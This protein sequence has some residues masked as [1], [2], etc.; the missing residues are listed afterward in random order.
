MRQQNT[1]ELAER[2]FPGDP[3]VPAIA[4]TIDRDDLAL[5]RYMVMRHWYRLSRFKT[6]DRNLKKH[7]R[8]PAWLAQGLAWCSK[9][10]I[11]PP[12][13]FLEYAAR[14]SDPNYPSVKAPTP[15]KMVAAEEM[16]VAID[17]IMQLAT[18]PWVVEGNLIPA[19]ERGRFAEI[20]ME[21]LKKPEDDSAEHYQRLLGDAED[22]CK[23][24]W[25]RW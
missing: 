19:G 12:H 13:L 14:L 17:I 2:L 6:K 9:H 10:C 7:E 23:E 8:N 21:R 25:G 18:D 20:L 1:L 22:I 3:M 5:G 15:S 16:S 4:D 24:L 11:T